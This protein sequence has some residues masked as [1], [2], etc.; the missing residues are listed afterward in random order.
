MDIFL[1]CPSLIL[2]P[3]NL[4]SSVGTLVTITLYDQANYKVYF[5]FFSSTIN[6]KQK[7]KN[8]ID[9][10]AFDNSRTIQNLA[11]AFAGECMEGA[12]YQFIAQKAQQEGYEYIQTLLKTVAKNEMAHAKE[13]Y[14]HITQNSTKGVANINIDAG[15]PFPC[16]ELV[17]NLKHC[18]E[19]E[20]GESQ[21]IYPAFAQIAE[22]EGYPDIAHTFRLVATVENCHY[23]LMKQLYEKLKKNKLYTC[24][25]SQK[26]K[27]NDCGFEHTDKK[28]WETCPLCHKEQGC[29]QIP[30][31]TG[32]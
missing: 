25:C 27:C 3:V 11:R 1:Y 15:Y 22:E 10:K 31:D 30:I 24:K 7:E 19:Y 21:D 9:K 13:F 16:G 18:L 17:D 28:A 12:R 4:I 5:L 29:V 2:Y 6:K 32:Q 26:W 14:M 23:L 8:M 20:A